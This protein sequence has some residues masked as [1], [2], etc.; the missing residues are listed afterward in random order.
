MR[1]GNRGSGL[2][3]FPHP[4]GPNVA[5]L[6]LSPCCR[7]Q[8]SLFLWKKQV[9]YK[10]HFHQNVKKICG[11]M[12]K[13]SNIYFGECEQEESVICASDAS[14]PMKQIP[15][16]P[17]ASLRKRRGKRRIP[18]DTDTVNT[19]SCFWIISVSTQF[20]RNSARLWNQFDK[21]IKPW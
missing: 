2:F 12:K 1:T 13:G 11:F 3:M 5:T 21:L 6:Y 8:E 15:S 19:T 4:T 10:V 20:S 14:L 18:R 9:L 16:G 17:P 7:S